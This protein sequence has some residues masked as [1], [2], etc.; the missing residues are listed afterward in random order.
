MERWSP[1]LLHF[2][3]FI[4][5]VVCLKR[6]ENRWILLPP[7][8]IMIDACSMQLTLRS[9]PTQMS[10]ASSFTGINS[11]KFTP[12]LHSQTCNARDS[13]SA[14]EHNQSRRRLSPNVFSKL[15]TLAGQPLFSVGIVRVES[16][17]ACGPI[18]VFDRKCE[19][20]LVLIYTDSK[21]Q[22]SCAKHKHLF[23]V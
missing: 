11:R 9:V 1:L 13:T 18:L 8:D 16:F 7:A 15:P 19:F 12:R 14:L 20:L 10:S 4:C 21:T 3:S 23:C 2:A 6:F 17:V 22:K 5:C